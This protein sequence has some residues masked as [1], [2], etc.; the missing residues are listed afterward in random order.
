[1]AIKLNIICTAAKTCAQGDRC[2]IVNPIKVLDPKDAGGDFCPV[3]KTRLIR[4][5]LQIRCF[6]YTEK[7]G[8]YNER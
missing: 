8:T 3:L 7:R 5:D 4:R 6:S 1:M 2:L